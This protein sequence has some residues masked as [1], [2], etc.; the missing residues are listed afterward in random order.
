M[1]DILGFSRMEKEAEKHGD[2]FHNKLFDNLDSL[3]NQCLQNLSEYHRYTDGYIFVSDSM[4][5]AV[6]SL[7]KFICF[8]LASQIPLRAYLSV[9]DIRISHSNKSGLTISGAGLHKIN[10][11]EKAL[12]W[13]GGLLYLPEHDDRHIDEIND[14]ISNLDII[15]PNTHGLLLNPSKPD[16]NLIEG[17]YWYLNW[18]KPLKL[19]QEKIKTLIN[20]WWSSYPRQNNIDSEDV[21]L[22]KKNTI[23][24]GNY[25]YELRNSIYKLCLAGVISE[26]YWN[27][28]N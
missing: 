14:L 11:Y 15:K 20:Q 25:C 8:S 9:G 21:I 4:T 2:F 10:T 1:I 26:S 12:N 7:N 16:T 5:N 23:E 6:N 22:K 19:D 27:A 3:A 13:M 18:Q 17:K 24:Y 28:I